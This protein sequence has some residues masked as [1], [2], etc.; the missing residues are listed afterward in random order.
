MMKNYMGPRTIFSGAR[1]LFIVVVIGLFLSVN[2]GA[3]PS[4]D[5]RTLQGTVASGGTGLAGYSVSLYGSFVEH[6]PRWRLLGSDTSDSSGA[7]TIKY[8]IPPGLLNDQQPIL[9]VEAQRG[10]AM[11]ASAIGVGSSAPDNIVVNELTTVATGNAFAQFIED[12]KVTG[13][14]YGML[15]AVNM[16]ANFANPE[17]GEAGI[18]LSSTPNGVETTT[19]AT[20]N[21]LANT[22]ASCV[23]DSSN[24]S[25]L[26][27]AATPPGGSQPE[28]VLKAISNIV[29]S[30]AYPGYPDNAQDPVFLLSQLN[31]IY[32]PA[33]PQRPTSWLL[34]LKITGGFYKDQD[35]T[36]LMNGPGNF[37]IDEKGFVWVND[38]YIPQPPDHFTCAGL[39]LM[40]FYPWGES[41][42][43]SPFT[44]GGLSGAGFGITLDPHGK[45][46]VGNFGFQD[47]PCD[48]LP[49]N[50]PHNSVSKFRPD[51]TPVSG[52]D[53]YTNGKIFWPQGTVSDRKG[54]IWIA[55]CGNDSVTMFP[56]GDRH[57][58]INIA[59][60]GAPGIGPQLKP[61]GV[62]IDLDGNAW[63]VGN[64]SNTVWVI[65]PK[66]KVIKTLTATYQGRTV[67]THPIGN[68]ADSKGN[69]WVANSDWL[70]AP[71]PTRLQLGTAANPSVA[72]FDMKT[73]LPFPGAPFSGGGITLPWGVS[74]DGDDTVWVFNF[75][76]VPVGSTTDTPT[77][78][79][80]L[81][82]VK[83]RK[84]PPGLRVGDPISPSTG[85]QS[86]ALERVTGG[87]IDPSGNI[88]MTNNW[89]LDANPLKNPGGNAIVI[90]IGAAAPL[91]TPLIGPPTGFK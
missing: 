42:P 49:Q 32:Q 69:I 78:I 56:R 6:G 28:N 54:S 43:G 3:S 80:R 62:S 55:N 36:N 89:K 61:F 5:R 91:R 59:L 44:G 48:Q 72:M 65:S 25:T 7:F 10:S 20:F 51:G 27:A 19:F 41:V 75:G 70:D 86:N 34:F 71:C 77:G 73:K 37:A 13:N 16:A 82:G 2:A 47:P 58:A 52:P 87:Q 35:A 67:L 85:Y 88:W 40:K 76:V 63:V 12:N 14:L 50:S 33:L 68:A 8:S 38:N 4:K 84:C 17:T 18:V 23:A 79:S 74:V 64:R 66:G 39:T 45:V 53:G 24:C 22:V 1:S 15:N 57:Q 60:N 90:V 21:S 46:W 30:P 9:F 11:L 26:F 83:T 81:C 29:K 31:A